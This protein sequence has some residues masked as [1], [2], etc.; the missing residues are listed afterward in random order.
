MPHGAPRPLRAVGGLGSVLGPDLKK[1]RHKGP[2][3]AACACQLVA[4]TVPGLTPNRLSM[5]SSSIT[6]LTGRTPSS[7]FESTAAPLSRMQQRS[8]WGA[9]A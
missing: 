3:E 4:L 5:F 9:V 1:A 8:G 2:M 6:F 7:A